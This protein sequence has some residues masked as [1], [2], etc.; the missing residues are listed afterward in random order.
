MNLVLI[1]VDSV[2]FVFIVLMI[3][4]SLYSNIRNNKK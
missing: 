2:A 1:I 3:V 4:G